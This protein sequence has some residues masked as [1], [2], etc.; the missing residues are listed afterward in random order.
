[1]QQTIDTIQHIFIIKPLKNLG[2]KG[3]LLN[4]PKNIY[5]KPTATITLKTDAFPLIWGIKS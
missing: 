1:M 4:F 3:N 5:I 2:I